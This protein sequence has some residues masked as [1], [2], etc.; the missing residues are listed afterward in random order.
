MIQKLKSPVYSRY[1]SVQETL[2]ELRRNRTV[3]SRLLKIV[4]MITRAGKWRKQGSKEEV[5]MVLPLL[6]QSDAN[7]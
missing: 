5:V 1:T 3:L 4:V 6:A 7:A 2:F